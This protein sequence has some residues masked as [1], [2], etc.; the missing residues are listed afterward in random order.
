MPL[1]TRDDG[2]LYIEQAA[3]LAKVRP[4]TIQ[5]WVER[6]HLQR[7][8]YDYRTGRNGRAYRVSLFRVSD[9]RQAEAKLRRPARRIIIPA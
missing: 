6:G 4:G 9:V 3:A 8:G 5:A 7:A 1:V 2:L